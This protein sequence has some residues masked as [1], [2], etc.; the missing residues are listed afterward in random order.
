MEHAVAAIP[1]PH[2]GHLRGRRAA[3][4]R[5]CLRL[6]VATAYLLLIRVRQLQQEQ[7]REDS[8]DADD[9]DRWELSGLAVDNEREPPGSRTDPTAGCSTS[10]ISCSAGGTAWSE[11][12]RTVAGKQVPGADSGLLTDRSSHMAGP[13]STAGHFSY[14]GNP[15]TGRHSSS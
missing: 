15:W 1:K 8:H 11:A 2:H 14:R 5:R 4:R 13:L 7:Q 6:I 3:P 10:R 12:R 9:V